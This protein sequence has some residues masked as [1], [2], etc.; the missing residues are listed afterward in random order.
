MT[1]R[2]FLS[3]KRYAWKDPDGTE[4][5]GVALKY[6]AQ[7]KAHLTPEECRAMADK[8]HDLADQTEQA[9]SRE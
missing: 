7:I 3:I 4:T 5:P 1:K 6:G 9:G 8:L 2:P